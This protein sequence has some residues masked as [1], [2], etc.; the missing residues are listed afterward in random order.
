MTGRCCGSWSE[1]ILLW[2]WSKEALLRGRRLIDGRRVLRLGRRHFRYTSF[3]SG[4]ILSSWTSPASSSGGYA[5]SS[6]L[7]MVVH[8][9]ASFKR[10]VLFRHFQLIFRGCYVNPGTVF[11]VKDFVGGMFL[12]GSTFGDFLRKFEAFLRKKYKEYENS[13]QLTSQV[14]KTNQPSTQT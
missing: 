3:R 12:R 8:A 14:K 4:V 2:S 13:E 9:S 6:T 10:A 1:E 11:Y 5:A 7:G